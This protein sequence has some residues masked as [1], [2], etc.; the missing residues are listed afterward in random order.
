MERGSTTSDLTSNTSSTDTFQGCNITVLVQIPG[1]VFGS[2][3]GRDLEASSKKTPRVLELESCDA[4]E[5]NMFVRAL[6][7]LSVHVYSSATN[8]RAS[9]D[10]SPST[11]RLAKWSTLPRPKFSRSRAMAI[12]VTSPYSTLVQFSSQQDIAL[13]HEIRNAR[14]SGIFN[15]GK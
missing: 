12:T 11:A 4:A 8:T 13:V 3:S 1:Y 14:G 10:C 15:Y 6:A 5:T 9:A 7:Y 2:S